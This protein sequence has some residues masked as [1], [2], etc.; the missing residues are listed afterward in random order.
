MAELIVPPRQKK[1]IEQA[2]SEYAVQLNQQERQKAALRAFRKQQR[3]QTKP[4]QRRQ[5]YAASES[6]TSISDT[7]SVTSFVPDVAPSLV[8]REV[9]QDRRKAYFRGGKSYY[10][11]RNG[12]VREKKDLPRNVTRKKGERKYKNKIVTVLE[13]GTRVYVDRVVGNRAQISKP[14]KGWLSTVTANGQLLSQWN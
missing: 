1:W 14:V 8:Q 4:S 3:T 9:S 13:A 7:S 5:S 12:T 6:G 10:L 11:M 2:K